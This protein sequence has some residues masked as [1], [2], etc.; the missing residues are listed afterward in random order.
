MRMHKHISLVV[1]LTM[2]LSFFSCG[3]SNVSGGAGNNDVAFDPSTTANLEVVHFTVLQNRLLVD[4]DLPNGSEAINLLNQQQSIFRVP[5]PK[6]SA[7][8]AVY[9][10]NIITL[11]CKQMVD[12]ALFP[13]GPDMDFAWK[14]ITGRSMDEGS[15]KLEADVLAALDGRPDDEKI[16]ALCFAVNM[17]AKAM[18]INFVD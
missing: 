3:N 1:V 15:K 10:A 4:F 2:T 11:A 13:D 8:Y 16:F 5:N 7:V 17:D 18:F 14:A 6:Y 9:Y 12:E